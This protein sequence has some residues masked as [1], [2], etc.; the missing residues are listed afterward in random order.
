VVADLYGGVIKAA[1]AQ[2]DKEDRMADSLVWL[3]DQC[4]FFAQHPEAIHALRA[5]LEQGKTPAAAERAALMASRVT[6]PVGGSMISVL[7]LITGG[8]A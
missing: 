1:I 7:R 5:A 4:I 6:R 3:R 2:A 8:K